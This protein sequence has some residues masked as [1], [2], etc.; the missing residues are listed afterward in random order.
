MLVTQTSWRAG[1]AGT[2]GIGH[3]ALRPCGITNDRI[4]GSVLHAA[5]GNVIAAERCT[6]LQGGGIHAVA[7][8]EALTMAILRENDSATLHQRIYAIC[9]LSEILTIG[10]R[11][12]QAMNTS[13][14]QIFPKVH[15]LSVVII[16]LICARRE[17]FHDILL[18]TGISNPRATSHVC[19]RW[20]SFEN[21]SP[22]LRSGFRR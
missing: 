17:H 21:Q 20:S 10:Y 6:L 8:G 13:P 14:A 15:I 11:R 19:G 22:C 7:K 16:P 4:D 1:G 2:W 3:R 9:P 12:I 18:M 5:T